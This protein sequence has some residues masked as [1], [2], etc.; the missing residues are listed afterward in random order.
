MPFPW[1]ILNIKAS[2]DPLLH[3]DL[4]GS[5]LQLV[6]IPSQLLVD[7]ILKESL[8]QPLPFKLPK[9]VDSA[10]LPFVTRIQLLGTC[11]GLF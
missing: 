6:S 1:L 5:A 8:F 10:W 3:L 9:A 4:R 7:D 2:S 11:Y